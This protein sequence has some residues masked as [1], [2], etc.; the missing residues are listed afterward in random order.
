M[1]FGGEIKNQIIRLVQ[2]PCDYFGA[3]NPLLGDWRISLGI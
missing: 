3:K 1:N 2:L